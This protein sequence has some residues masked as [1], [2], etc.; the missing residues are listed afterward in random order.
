MGMVMFKAS[1]LNRHGNAQPYSYDSI[2]WDMNEFKV[3]SDY[4]EKLYPKSKGN[5]TRQCIIVTVMEK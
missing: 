3:S 4:I 5:Q 1:Y 2:L